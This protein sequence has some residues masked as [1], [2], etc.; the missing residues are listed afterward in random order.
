MLVRLVAA[1]AI[2][3]LGSAA[4]LAQ[5]GAAG[6]GTPAPAAGA[7]A[8]AGNSGAGQN[9]AAGATADTPAQ[10]VDESA[11]RYFAQQ[12]DL[13]RLEAEIR[14]L[15]A[16]Y[17]NWQPP[18]D[19]LDPKA[20]GGPSDVQPVWDL[21]GE[22]RIAEARRA[23]GRLQASK[24]GWQPP[25]DLVAAL[26]EAEARQRMINAAANKQWNTVLTI[27]GQTPS[28]LVCGRVDVLWLVADAFIATNKPSRASDVY[29]Y[30][31]KNCT[32]TNERRATIDRAVA[33]LPSAMVTP[34]F[35]MERIGPDGKGEFSGP[36]LDFIRRLVGDA[37]RD[38]SVVVPEEELSLLE[39]AARESK[40]PDDAN[41]LGFYFT[42]H[43]DTTQA[44]EW[45]KESLD[46][47][48]G[49][50]AAEGYVYA[51]HAA[52][53]DLRAEPTAYKWRDASDANMVAYILLVSTLLN[54]PSQTGKP[55]ELITATPVDQDVVNRF[56]PVVMQRHSPL[57]ALSL[58]WYA[59]NTRQTAAAADWF[60]QSLAWQPSEAAAFGLGLA[61][62]ALG[63][64]AGLQNAVE[65]WKS[66][67]P[68]LPS[69]LQSALNPATAATAAEAG[70][71][72]SG[73]TAVAAG[74]AQLAPGQ[75][76]VASPV[77][78]AP[79][80]TAIRGTA[81]AGSAVVA[82]AAASGGAVTQ[83]A[84]DAG[85]PMVATS[86]PAGGGGRSSG[87]VLSPRPQI[88]SQSRPSGCGAL[89]GRTGRLSASQSLTKGWCLLDLNRPM[90]AAVAFG[91]AMDGAPG[92][93]TASDAAYGRSLAYL[94]AGLTDN[95]AVAAAA[96]P[97]DLSR[98]ADLGVQILS[99]RAVSAYQAG[100]YVDAILAM[101]QRNAI[102]PE[103]R[104]DMLLRGW[105]YYNLGE[106]ATARR[107]FE[108][109]DRAASTK[110]S[111]RALAVVFDRQRIR[112]SGG[113]N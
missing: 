27:A 31:L 7:A 61:L 18:V 92:T 84:S 90:E 41:L 74:E 72:S 46:R 70:K 54:P 12:G 73:R 62:N 25:A 52:G 48:G 77:G 102:V 83:V 100:R 35:A 112:T 111:R 79:A 56:V 42:R 49:A 110:E 16:L 33:K 40:S 29:S 24:P 45:F 86:A 21:Y 87:G 113:A 17:P 105:A 95:A 91:A 50:K 3:L 51:M 43:G 19:L 71:T 6:T 4:A 53:Q 98:R 94:R 55:P 34:L 96:A 60:R 80:A 39:A 69:L 36:R 93:Q 89:V 13:N 108:A 64:T 107:I 8:T 22:G 82:T 66:Q 106:V 75:A 85:G 101:E 9:P 57:G 59:M 1:L 97:Q 104:E 58:G 103:S 2:L 37:S 14:R 67:F 88:Q 78:T 15:K 65:T 99:Q 32:N 20:G 5:S 47:G 81:P 38:E 23:M 76:R 26:N 30:I 10:T 44:Y 11:L 28:L 68:R 63:D 109:V